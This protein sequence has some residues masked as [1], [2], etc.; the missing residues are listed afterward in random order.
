MTRQ[1]TCRQLRTHPELEKR[2]DISNGEARLAAEAAVAMMHG[3]IV[4]L[5][6]RDRAEQ[7]LRHIA[8]R[9]H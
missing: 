1:Y 5:S 3:E 6:I 9:Y 7:T 2:P 8:G 4:P